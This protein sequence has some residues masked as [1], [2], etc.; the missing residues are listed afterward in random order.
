M[1]SLKTP[2]AALVLILG[3]IASG[4]FGMWLAIASSLQEPDI[5]HAVGA[6]AIVTFSLTALALIRRSWARLPLLVT[7]FYA[8]ALIWDGFFV[9]YDPSAMTM[10]G[11]FVYNVIL[12][13]FAVLALIASTWDRIAAAPEPEARS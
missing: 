2:R 5:D 7:G 12:T 10:L 6:T 8:G 9:G 13:F 4:V 11:Y 3:V 1:T